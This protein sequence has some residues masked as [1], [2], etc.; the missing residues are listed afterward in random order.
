MSLKPKRVNFDEKWMDLRE[1]VKEVIT[2]GQVNK[3]IWNDRFSYV[4]KQPTLIQYL[5]RF[6]GKN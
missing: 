6:E 3:T 4:F 1:T 2:L 5:N